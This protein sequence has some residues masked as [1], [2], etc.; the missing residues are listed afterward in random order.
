M[1]SILTA[2]SQIHEGS[3]ETLK[4]MILPVT[5]AKGYVILSMKILNQR[6]VAKIYNEL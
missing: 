6:G 2:E 3:N 4:S 1:F 5:Q